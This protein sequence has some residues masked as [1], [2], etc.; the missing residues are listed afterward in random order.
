MCHLGA[1]GDLG[2]EAG[3]AGC[4][5]WEL[6]CLVVHPLVVQALVVHPMQLQTPLEGVE[7]AVVEQQ[8]AGEQAEGQQF[9]GELASIVRC[10]SP[11]KRSSGSNG[12]ATAHHV[13]AYC[14]CRQGTVQGCTSDI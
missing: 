1:V 12:F 7:Q 6:Q 3:P 4:Q 2:R 11:K 10:R 5:Q 14:C 9:A 13:L 8:F